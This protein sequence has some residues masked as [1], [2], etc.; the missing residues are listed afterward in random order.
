MTIPTNSQTDSCRN[1]NAL[2][3][4]LRGI[5]PLES[6]QMSDTATALSKTSLS[7]NHS[8]VKAAGVIGVATFSSR[9]LGFIR[10]MV[11]ARLFGATPAADAFYVAFRIPSLLRELFAEGS[12]S[13]AFIPVFTEYHSLKSK[14]EAWELASAVFTTLLTIVTLGDIARHSHRAL[15]RPGSGTGLSCLAGETGAHDGPG[16]DHVSLSSLH[17]SRRAGDGHLEF[18]PGL[19]RPGLCGALPERVHHRM[20]TVSVPAIRGTDCRCGDR[21]RGRRSGSVPHADPQPQGE[22]IFIRHPL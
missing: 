5:V 6:A 13:A 10:D 15:A 4:R 21:R 16:P 12:M 3:N 9:I 11:L 19:C 8:L 17:Q 2:F 22:R 20:R 1:H 18:A 7:E 14:R